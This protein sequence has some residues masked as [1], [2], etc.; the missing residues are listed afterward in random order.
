M[1]ENFCAMLFALSQYE[2][3]VI[4]STCPIR[5]FTDQNPTLFYFTR[6]GNLTP[7]QYNA[8]NFLKTSKRVTLLALI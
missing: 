7:R 4:D 6:R 3:E 1:I 8:Q 2:F 5:V